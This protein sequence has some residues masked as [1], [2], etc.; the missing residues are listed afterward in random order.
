MGQPLQFNE[1]SSNQLCKPNLALGQHI[2]VELYHCSNAVI[3]DAAQIEQSMKEAAVQC[4]ATIVQAWFHHF[5]PLGVSGIILIQESHLTIHTWPEYDYAA[6]DL[7]TCSP[8]ID[9]WAA[10]QVLKNALG[11]KHT[12]VTTVE[13]GHLQYFASH[14]PS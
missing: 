6:V 3:Q 7:F 14:E 4:G 13:R 2:L 1:L 5:S 9:P 12:V 10:Y 8:A 11:A